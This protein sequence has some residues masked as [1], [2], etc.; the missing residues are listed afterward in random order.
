M[1]D[2]VK[3]NPA[4]GFLGPLGMGL[5]TLQ[6]Q[7]D[8]MFQGPNFVPPHRRDVFTTETEAHV[9]DTCIPHDTPFWETG[10]QAKSSGTWI[11]VEQYGKDRSEAE[12]GHE[13]W[14]K[15]ITEDPNMELTDIYIEDYLNDSSDEFDEEYDWED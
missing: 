4:K 8:N 6:S 2:K 12:A 3:K 1:S 9:I 11:I 7:V 15:A 5:N 13:K 10:I 14:V